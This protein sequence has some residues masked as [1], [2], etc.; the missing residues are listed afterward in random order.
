MFEVGFS[1]LCMVALVALLVIGPEQLPKFARVSGYWIGKIRASVTRMKMEVQAELHAEEMRQLLNQQNS[2]H[3]IL[4]E[5]DKLINDIK[6][7]S[8]RLLS[9]PEKKTD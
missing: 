8:A 7:E 9:E 3:N 2:I 5:G 6:N 4:N 1:E